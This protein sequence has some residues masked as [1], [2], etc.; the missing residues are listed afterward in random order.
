[1]H[2]DTLTRKEHPVAALAKSKV[3][4]DLGKISVGV[5]ALDCGFNF[6]NLVKG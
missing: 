6:L 5:K 1:M 3:V 4:G 2:A